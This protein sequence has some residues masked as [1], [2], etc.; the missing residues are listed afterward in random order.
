M[1]DLRQSMWNI[2]LELLKELY[3]HFHNAY[4]H[5]TFQDGDLT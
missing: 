4:G 1:V 3:I 5:Q 2:A